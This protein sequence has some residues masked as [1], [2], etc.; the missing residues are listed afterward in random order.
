M[1]TS[2]IPVP[3]NRR[4]TAAIADA[5]TERKMARNPG[6]LRYRSGKIDPVAG[7]VLSARRF[8]AGL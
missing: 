2:L 7:L 5:A 1:A 6:D 8:D 4:A 3:F